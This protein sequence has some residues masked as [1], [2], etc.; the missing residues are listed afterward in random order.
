MHCIVGAKNKLS[1]PGNHYTEFGARP[2]THL[3]HTS[4]KLIAHIYEGQSAGIIDHR[5]T[6]MASLK[7]LCDGL[8]IDPLPSPRDRD[9]SV[10][11]APART[12][13]LSADE[14]RVWNLLDILRKSLKGRR[15][16]VK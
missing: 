12:V 4:T 8:P 9:D 1:V 15:Q 7:E 16:L 6:K 3:Q 13:N 10:P 11:H 2:L 14:R 5:R